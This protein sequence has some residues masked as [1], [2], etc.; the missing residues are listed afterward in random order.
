MVAYVCNLSFLGGGDQDDGSLR[1]TKKLV[2][3]SP[4]FRQTSM[5]VIPARGGLCEKHEI[6]PEKGL[7]QKVLG[8]RLK[9]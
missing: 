6:L 5:P 4:P 3:P 2:R 7:K 9:W 1:P 8:V